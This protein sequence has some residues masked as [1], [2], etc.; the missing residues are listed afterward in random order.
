[1]V[2]GCLARGEGGDR[3]AHDEPLERSPRLRGQPPKRA[4]GHAGEEVTD[5]DREWARRTA[6]GLPP[7]TDGQRDILALLLSRRR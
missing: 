3:D 4:T 1:V 5:E 7:L 6:A 2:K